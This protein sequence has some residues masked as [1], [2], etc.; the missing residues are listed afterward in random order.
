MTAA[1]RIKELEAQLK[2]WETWGVI[3]IAVRNP[4]VASYMNHWEGRATQAEAQLAATGWQPLT[5]DTK[6]PGEG[7]LAGKWVS[8][9]WWAQ[10]WYPA[11]LAQDLL[12]MG[13][14]HYLYVPPPQKGGE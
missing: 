13:Y 5:A 11:H 9:T 12:D 3:E 6:W 10:E 14:T 7:A 8:R 2:E 4:N 1:E